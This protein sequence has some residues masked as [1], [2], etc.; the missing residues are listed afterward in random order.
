MLCMYSTE[1]SRTVVIRGYDHINSD[2]KKV[3]LGRE[4]LRGMRE[5]GKD[6]DISRGN[7]K[8]EGDE[9]LIQKAGAQEGGLF[10]SAVKDRQ[11]LPEV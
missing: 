2:N 6:R 4:K 1:H 11:T 5:R 7:M 10:P 9:E 8:T 3:R